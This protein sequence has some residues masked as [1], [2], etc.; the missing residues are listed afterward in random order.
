MI[1]DN[2]YIKVQD[3]PN[4]V[5]DRFTGALVNINKQEIQRRKQILEAKRKQ[6]QEYEQLKS[7][8]AE[9]KDLLRQLINK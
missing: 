7:D 1:D 2:R 3:E 9:I 6:K 8:V 5:R 4:F